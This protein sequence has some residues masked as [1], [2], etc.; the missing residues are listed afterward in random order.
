MLFFEIVK[1]GLSIALKENK[2]CKEKTTC[3]RFL[4]T[5]FVLVIDKNYTILTVRSAKWKNLDN[6]SC[7][8]K[9]VFEDYVNNKDLEYIVNNIECQTEGYFI[10]VD[11]VNDSAILEFKDKCD[12][13]FEVNL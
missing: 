5:K 4:K 10:D 2:L 1:K 7:E 8:V 11:Y 9:W 12:C 13:C 6:G 3:I